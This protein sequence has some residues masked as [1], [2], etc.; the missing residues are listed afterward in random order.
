MMMMMTLPMEIKGE[1]TPHSKVGLFRRPLRG[2]FGAMLEPESGFKLSLEIFL[3]SRDLVVF[4][5]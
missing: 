2:T 4:P 5:L 1:E 3:A